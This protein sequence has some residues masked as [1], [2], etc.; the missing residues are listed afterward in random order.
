MK[1]KEDEFVKKDNVKEKQGEDENNKDEA[2]A[3]KTSE[4]E[5]KQSDEKE[6][7]EE[8]EI[9]R[10]DREK[11]AKELQE[12]QDKVLRISADTDNYRKR[13]AKES[14]DK[15][16]YANQG[17]I[18][19]LLNV[20]DHLEM[21]LDHSAEDSNVEA[22]RDGVELTLKQ[23]KNVLKKY[24]VEE[25]KAKEG[26]I[27]DPNVHEAMMLD[28]RHDL[29]NNCISTVMQKGYKL[30]NRVIRSSKVRV[31]KKEEKNN[32]QEENNE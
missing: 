7:D 28:E 32:T 18:L 30:H 31:N 3:G 14:E 9:L 6:K 23:F 11:L 24:G 12:A 22:L 27:F 10:K 15:V 29:E 5:E 8:V 17:L 19:D 21:A 20:V 26:D 1:N 2:T 4:S 25:I 13:L 16:K